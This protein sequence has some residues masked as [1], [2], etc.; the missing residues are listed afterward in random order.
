MPETQIGRTLTKHFTSST[1]CIL[2]RFHGSDAE[3]SGFI[4]SCWV[5]I[6]ALS[7]NLLI[8]TN[9]LELTH[10]MNKS[11]K[12][13]IAFAKVKLRSRTFDAI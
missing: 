1:C 5:I 13:K 7:R 2:H 9:I 3:P 11:A 6:A 12:G 10:S 8:H 4:L